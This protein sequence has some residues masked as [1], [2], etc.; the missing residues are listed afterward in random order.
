VA[1]WDHLELAEQEA[2][3][4][5]LAVTADGE[6]DVALAEVDSLFGASA[7]SVTDWLARQ[8]LCVVAAKLALEI[9]HVR[10]NPRTGLIAKLSKEL[11]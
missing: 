7:Q 3:V 1:C 6:L 8:P 4:A 2:W 10:E 9:E 5:Q 11:P